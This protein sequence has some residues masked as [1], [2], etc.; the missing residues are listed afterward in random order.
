MPSSPRA[1]AVQPQQGAV[2]G[3]GIDRRP[4]I[5]HRGEIADAAQQAHR[6]PRGA[7]SEA[8]DLGGAVRL[9]R[10]GQHPRAP[11]ATISANSAG[12]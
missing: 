4:S 10:K 8:R 11:R 7:A 9:Q 3:F 6:H 12:S 2:G 5:L 1:S